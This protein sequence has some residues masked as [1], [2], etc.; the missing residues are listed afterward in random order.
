MTPTVR[1]E[2]IRKDKEITDPKEIADIIEQAEVCRVAMA[3]NGMPYVVPMCFGF[4]DNALYLHSA[5]KGKKI[6]TLRK[7][8]AVCFEMDVDTEVK[9]GDTACKWG[10]GFR[11]VI[12]FGRAV[13]LEDPEAKRRALDIIMAHYASRY[14][15]GK[16]TYSESA[17]SA[18]TV[19]RIDVESMTGK[20]AG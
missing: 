4:S 5:G 19:I 9:P 14:E 12:G 11:S 8:N 17:L 10:M 2:M 7:H 1:L 20:K 3:D 15:F 6:D 13:F 16:F 18:T